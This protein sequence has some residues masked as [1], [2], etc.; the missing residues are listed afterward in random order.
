MDNQETLDTE[1]QDSQL[2]DEELDLELD[3]EDDEI[4]EEEEEPVVT[5]PAGEG[6]SKK[7]FEEMT[8]EELLVKARTYH[9]IIKKRNKPKP[10]QQPKSSSKPEV[11]DDIKAT[12]NQ[13]ALKDKMLDFGLE[14]GLSREEV[15]A[16]F[17]IN[18]NP[19]KETLNDP[20]VKGGLQAIRA[21]KA[22]ENA[23]PGSS[24]R[25]ATV[26]GKTW[27]EMSKEEKAKNYSTVI[28]KS[29]GR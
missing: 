28:A 13:L 3:L 21:K 18:S 8:R 27:T 6:K 22:I 12:V 23:T 25:S 24:K 2:P 26:D 10:D 20:F 11:D 17:K 7:R 9:G 4:E 15:T 16:I 14:H 1:L 19:S 29:V 5:P